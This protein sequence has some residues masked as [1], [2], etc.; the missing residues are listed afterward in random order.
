MDYC[1]IEWFALETWYLSDAFK[2]KIYFSFICF[3]NCSWQENWFDI[4]KLPHLECT[5]L[6]LKLK[7]KLLIIEWLENFSYINKYAQSRFLI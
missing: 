1:D 6:F 3:V 5:F 7:D 4:S 2:N